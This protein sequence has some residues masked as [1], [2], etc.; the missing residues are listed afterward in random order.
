MPMTHEK[1]KT[2]VERYQ[3]KMLEAIEPAPAEEIA[4]LEALAGPLPDTYRDFL[5]W[6]GNRCPFLDGEELGYSP[7]RLLD[8]VYED[9]DI[10]VTPGFI[11]IGVDMS[12]SSMSLHLRREDGAAVRLSLYYEPGQTEGLLLENVSF[13]SYLLTTYVRHTLAPS[14]PY[15]FAAAFHGDASQI[16][17]LW[18]RVDEACSHFEI[19]YRIVFPDF[20]FYGGQDFV[21]G[22]HQRPKS[23][24]VNLHFGAIERA[25]HEPWYDLAFARWRLQPLPL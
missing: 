22:V 8:F 17:E 7:E 13:E 20:R 4:K 10:E 25:R 16:E 12:G 6:M 24:V 21:L 14:H 11:L 2:V 9:P 19:P 1:L 15:Q 3:P 18:R 5:V 23:P